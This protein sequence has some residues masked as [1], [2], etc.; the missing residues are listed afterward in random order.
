M[1]KPVIA[2]ST[3][4]K[5]GATASMNWFLDSKE[6]APVAATFRPLIN[7]KEAFTTLHE[8]IE[9]AEH[10]ID[11][12]IWGFQPSMHLK[13]DGKSKCIGDLLIEK[14]KAGVQVRILVWSI[15]FKIQT[16]SEAN[17]GNAPGVFSGGV[18]GVTKA[19][20]QYDRNWYLAR[21]GKL[22]TLDPHAS[23]N[24]Q[25]SYPH[26]WELSKSSYQNNLKFKTRSVESQSN[27]YEDK[28]LPGDAKAT[29]KIFPSHHQK[30]VLIDYEV[31]HKAVGFVMEHNMLDNYWDDNSHISGKVSA[32]NQGKNVDTPLQDVSSIVSGEV[33]W[34][35][36][37]NFCQSWDKV[38]SEKLGEKRKALTFDKYPFNKSAGGTPL[39]AQILRTYDKPDIEDIKKIY[40]QNIKRVTSYIYTENQY[41][42]WPP[43]AEAFI[44]HWQ[45]LRSKGRP[46]NM[47]I[48]WFVVTNS[49]DDG[50]GKGTY[51]TNKM[52]EKLGRQDV[53][54][55]V[56]LTDD[57]GRRDALNTTLMH[58]PRGV[59]GE[60]VNKWKKER[61]DLQ[62]RFNSREGMKERSYTKNA[63]EVREKEFAKKLKKELGVKVHVCT[64]TAS[65]AWKEVYIHSKV[66]I[67]DDVFTVIS[68][69]N[70]NT[71]SM[72][73]DTELGIFT[74]N[75]AV[76]RKLRKDLWK[77]HT[78]DLHKANNA[79]GKFDNVANP[80]GMNDPNI[81]KTAFERWEKIMQI[82]KAN[83]KGGKPPLH[84]LCEFLRLDPKISRLD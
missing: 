45:N 79:A 69:A 31:P 16:F 26:L 29:L 72:Q 34:Y 18:A 73:V 39:M 43:L 38:S 54:P 14:A 28:E 50:L 20:K 81:A 27:Q 3:K 21:E 55:N 61:D 44:K 84:P 78:R 53:M 75:G 7:G 11:I 56:A 13:R 57:N 74:E 83:I 66:T 30:T 1:G 65:N 51:T 41:F 52:L 2:T 77:L 60:T 80:E 12:A 10:S 19:Q 63:E 49:S 82:N 25:K 76:A 6:S 62:A 48:H 15:P 9:K 67:I 24:I 8:K 22:H 5:L 33:L 71:R 64:L 42:R 59:P 32:P 47:P 37:R 70:L 35:I 40:L 58:T 46:E 68:S 4:S 17:M 23:Q 36:N